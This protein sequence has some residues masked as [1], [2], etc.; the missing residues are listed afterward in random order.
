M[1]R[2]NIH[3]ECPPSAQLGIQLVGSADGGIVLSYVDEKG[4]AFHH[5]VREMDFLIN[6]NGCSV[7]GTTAYDAMA[8][9]IAFRDERKVAFTLD[10]MSATTSGRSMTMSNAASLVELET[11]LPKVLYDV[12]WTL[13]DGDFNF[14]LGRV[15][16][17]VLAVRN[18]VLDGR[19]TAIG[20]H[21]MRNGDV[22]LRVNGVEVSPRTTHEAWA[23]KPVVLR[24][25]RPLLSDKAE[26]AANM[27]DAIKDF[28]AL[29]SQCSLT[30]DDDDADRC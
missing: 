13:F 20:G 18:L 26:A 9:I 15:G 19:K 25:R 22:L 27:M 11:R 2:P 3:L 29:I 5:G 8:S 23:T 16:H 4:L 28:Q 6:I 17:N 1:L 12:V 14:T 7:L 24:F 10:V 21:H 30:N